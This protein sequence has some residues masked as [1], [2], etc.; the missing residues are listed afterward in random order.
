METVRD[1][2][3]SL[4]EETEQPKG[5]PEGWRIKIEE[6]TVLLTIR[7]RKTSPSIES[8]LFNFQSPMKKTDPLYGGV[9]QLGEHLPCK[10]G[11][12][13]S[14]LFISTR[15]REAEEEKPKRE[16]NKRGEVVRT[17]DWLI[18]QQARARA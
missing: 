2:R 9:A 17:Q 13:S 5:E 3:S 7:K 14:N 15:L 1:E 18:A 12:K 8:S 6:T 16:L 10:Q 4:S 11:V